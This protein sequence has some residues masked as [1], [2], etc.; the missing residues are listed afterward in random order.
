MT[1]S[2]KPPPVCSRPM[3]R[4]WIGSKRDICC[5]WTL[6]CIFQKAHDIPSGR[7]LKINYLIFW[8]FHTRLILAI[9]K[10]K[11]EK[12]A[13]VFF[14]WIPLNFLSIQRGKEKLFRINSTRPS[15]W[16]WMKLEKCWA[17]GKKAS[18]T[19]KRKTVATCSRD[20]KDHTGEY[21]T[22]TRC[23]DSTAS[24]AWRY[25]RSARVRRHCG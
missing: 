11:Q 9:K 18:T 21:G 22:R 16:S 17:V 10:R 7:E 14:F 12:L 4:S 20:G 5:G 3:R 1:E 25:C 24:S 15:R 2:F 8:K 19:Q 23:R 13:S 6:R